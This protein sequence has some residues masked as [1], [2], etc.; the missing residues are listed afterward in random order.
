MK[1]VSKD[2][3]PTG[4]EISLTDDQ[5]KAQPLL[6]S[7]AIIIT[8]F[9]INDAFYR[10]MMWA[11]KLGRLIHPKK[12]LALH[13]HGNGGTVSTALAIVD[14]IQQDGNIH[15][16]LLGTATSA[17]TMIW[18]ACQHRYVYPHAGIEI[19]PVAT[20]AWESRLQE[21]DYA[22][23]RHSIGWQNK[24]ILWIYANAST[25]SVKW[26]KK[27]YRKG[28]YTCV[29]LPAKKLIQIGMAQPARKCKS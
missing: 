23:Y 4:N 27:Q 22:N 24:Q 11:L 26:W 29:N 20:G 5:R 6:E 7:L 19:H 21:E 17:H 18:A 3:S 15:G 1:Q 12:P 28:G 9:E 13:C 2:A 14:L 25:K 16:F 8:P 10:E